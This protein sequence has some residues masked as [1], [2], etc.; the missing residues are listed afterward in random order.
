MDSYHEML[1]KVQHIDIWWREFCCNLDSILW[2][3]DACMKRK[4][5]WFLVDSS[6]KEEK[7][8]QFGHF[9]QY[10]NDYY[11]ID[12]ALYWQ[13]KSKEMP[14]FMYNLIQV[15]PDFMLVKSIF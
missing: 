8:G 15:R 1:K 2:N 13:C 3:S 7:I 10:T 14:S 9:F 4:G 6:S 11:T 5:W 12:E